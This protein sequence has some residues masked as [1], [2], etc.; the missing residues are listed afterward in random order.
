MGKEGEAIRK[1][2]V[3]LVGGRQTLPL[4]AGRLA[5]EWLINHDYTDIFIGYASYA[6]RLRQVNSLRVV[7][8]RNLI[9]PWL[10][11]ALPA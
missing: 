9:I 1:R 6:P 4:P 3:A 11:M 5:A 10:N 7:D 2:A 8:I